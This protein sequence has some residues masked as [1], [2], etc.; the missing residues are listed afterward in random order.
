LFSATFP[1]IVQ[2]W[3]NEYLKHQNVMVSNKKMVDA[4]TRVMQNFMKVYRSNKNDA[5]VKML[6][7][8]EEESKRDHRSVFQNR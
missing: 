6:R 7:T 4:N 8:E 1:T 2:E 5:L 3:A